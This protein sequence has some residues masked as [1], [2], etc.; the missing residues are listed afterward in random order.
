[1]ILRASGRVGEGVSFTRGVPAPLVWV[2]GLEK[3]L[4]VS[5]LFVV[6]TGDSVESTDD[7]FDRR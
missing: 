4:G 5:G 3:S 7:V 1:M 6:G 2:M